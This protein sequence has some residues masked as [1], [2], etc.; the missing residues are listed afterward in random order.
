MK[1]FWSCDKTLQPA[2]PRFA[3]SE[4]CEPYRGDTIQ[5]PIRCT[6]HQQLQFFNSK[7]LLLLLRLFRPSNHLSVLTFTSF[8]IT[9][10]KS[11]FH[12][13]STSRKIGL[14]AKILRQF[15]YRTVSR[16][17]YLHICSFLKMYLLYNIERW[18][19]NGNWEGC[20]RKQPCLD[21]RY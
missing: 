20:G 3:A 21:V 19:I 9:Q 13:N 8:A 12:C 4:E 15:A 14:S 11:P 7:S 17:C 18:D 16:L 1:L 2:V 10:C 5:R 6:V